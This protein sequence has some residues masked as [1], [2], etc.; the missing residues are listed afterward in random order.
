LILPE[1]LSDDVD[2]LCTFTDGA[3][4]EGSLGAIGLNFLAGLK[5]L[6]NAQR[7]AAYSYSS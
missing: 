2:G 1:L 7:N 5:K 4:S 3:N 6:Q